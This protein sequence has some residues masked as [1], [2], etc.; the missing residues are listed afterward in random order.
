MSS[1]PKT[2][3]AITKKALANQGNSVRAE[4]AGNYMKH[5]APFIGIAT[6]ERRAL[7]KAVWTDLS[8]PT[9]DDLG[10]AALSLFALP[11]RE[12]HYAACDLIAKY[13]ACADEYFL[14]E[15][16]E[17]LLTTKPWWDTVDGLVTAG[18]S[19]LCL[20]YDATK[21]IDEWSSSENIWLVRA[22]ICHQRGWKRETDIDRVLQICGQH[23]NQKE[24]FIAKAI[25]WALRDITRINPRAV[26]SFLQAH[27]SLNAVARREAERGLARCSQ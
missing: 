20:R 15:Y 5:V 18:V 27:P 4:S 21:I 12:Y 16:L 1:W 13:I 6:P 17:Q 19:P 14:A 26:G 2:V 11:Q 25:G 9:S 3:V 24:F 23:W 22:A 8:L 10:T 7:T